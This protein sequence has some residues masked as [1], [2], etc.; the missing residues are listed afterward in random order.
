MV[1]QL[2]A[3]KPESFRPSFQA[4][5]DLAQRHAAMINIKFEAIN[6]IKLWH[7][8]PLSLPGTPFISIWGVAFSRHK[9]GQQDGQDA[10]GEDPVKGPVT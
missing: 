5:P 1:C 10:G 7:L 3:S 9:A 4:G 8:S 2:K 6:H